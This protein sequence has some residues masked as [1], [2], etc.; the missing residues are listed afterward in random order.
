MAVL[1]L[2]PMAPGVGAEPAEPA[3]DDPVQRAMFALNT[4]RPQEAQ[5]IAEQILK[6]DPGHSRALHILGCALLV[7]G[8]AKD[9]VAP[10]E[11]VT[12]GRHDPEIETQLAVALEQA[13]RH[14]DALLRLKRTTKR[15][16]PYARA[17]HALGHLLVSMKRYDEAI[18]ALSRGIEIAPIM[19]ELS[20]ELGFALLHRRKCV[21]AKIAFTRALE[22]A[23]DSPDAL[24]G[25]GKAHQEIGE[26][27]TA[28]GYFR[29]YLMQSRDDA[30][31]WLTLGHC[32]LELGQR[33][34]GYECFRTAARGGRKHY[35]RALTS[36]AA[37][38]RG[39]FWLRP[40]A[41]ERFLRGTKS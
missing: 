8:R 37:S 23:P 32:L 16:P 20:N 25:M 33:E 36:L 21:E 30:G 15:Q 40:S 6:T 38:G 26:N 31:G 4:Q 14:D 7:Q 24:F 22:I 34:A 11:M 3:T 39:R 27:D 12:R 18:E 41:A 5:R 29:R 13:G 2:H 10:L 28:A 19:P 17:F 35:G 9:A 1:P